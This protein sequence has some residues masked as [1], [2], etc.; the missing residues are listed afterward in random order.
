M[1]QS[2]PKRNIDGVRRRTVRHIPRSRP[3]EMRDEFTDASSVPIK[4]ISKPQTRKTAPKPQSDFEASQF[5]DTYDYAKPRKSYKW[6]RPFLFVLL[7]LVLAWWVLELFEGTRVMV[8]PYIENPIINLDVYASRTASDDDL[9]FSVIA[10]TERQ[11][12][13]VIANGVDRV[14]EKASGTIR[15][16]NEYSSQPQRLV[17]ETR[18]ESVD[19]K[20]FKLGKGQGIV[21]PG[22]N[23]DTPGSVDAVVY[24]E[25]AG[26]SYNI[27]MTD[28]TIPGFKELGLDQKYRDMYALSVNP[29]SGGKIADE[30]IITEQQKLEYQSLLERGLETRLQEKLER[31][32]TDKFLV[33]ENSYFLEVNESEYSKGDG[34][35]GTLTQEAT[36]YALIINKEDLET[37]LTH[38]VIELEEGNE[39]FVPSFDKIKI[40]Y[41]GETPINY[42]TIKK[43]SLA[44]TSDIG[45]SFIWKVPEEE[46]A[47]ALSSV[48]KRD[49]ST[50]FDRF[51]SIEVADV[52]IRPFWR[53]RVSEDYDNISIAIRR[54]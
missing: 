18:F 44:I 53:N 24:A 50:I 45:V 46:L 34:N 20:I 27:E 51:Q 47:Q 40:D 4:I 13:Q 19:G 54:P 14:E 29:F 49:V 38:N 3:G 1:N 36:I 6:R 21:V 32:K 48:N 11:E 52:R 43:A 23:G 26:E 30:P 5:N 22:R 31:E 7:I 42:E 35:E 8:T 25:N 2:S 41:V 16:F 12:I 37:Y 10:V 17:E 39:A 33:A 28:F 9:G 15:I